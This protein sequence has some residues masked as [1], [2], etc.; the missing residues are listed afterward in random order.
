MQPYQAVRAIRGG[1]TIDI[2]LREQLMEGTVIDAETR[3]PIPGALVTL[4]PELALME[5]HA[6][7]TITDANGRFRIL[8]AASGPYRIIAWANGYAHTSQSLTL[9]SASR[10]FAFELRR[11]GELRVRISDARTNTPLEAHLIVTTPEGGFIPVRAQRSPDGDWYVFSLADGTYRL[12][13]IV[14]GYKEQVVAASAP[15]EIE[16]RME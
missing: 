12:T 10:Q 6:G 3:L 15:G 8:T 14:Q 9:G 16:I 13:A 2:E 5:A 7:E 4:A 11:S 1:E